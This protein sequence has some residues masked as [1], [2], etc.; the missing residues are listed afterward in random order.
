M[1]E[2][3]QI[4]LPELFRKNDLIKNLGQTLMGLEN[5]VYELD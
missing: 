3:L 4:K 2:L 1:A 5:I